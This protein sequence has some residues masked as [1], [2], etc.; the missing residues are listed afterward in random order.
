MQRPSTRKDTPRPW[1]SEC[2]KK[3]LFKKAKMPIQPD[4]STSI[5]LLQLNNQVTTILTRNLI[6]RSNSLISSNL[7]KTIT[8]MA[9]MRHITGMILPIIQMMGNHKTNTT[10]RSSSSHINNKTTATNF[11]KGI[12][13]TKRDRNGATSNRITITTSTETK[14]IFT[15]FLSRNKSKAALRSRSM[16]ILLSK[17]CHLQPSQQ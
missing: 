15:S 12:R 3:K 5:L 13:A 7:T 14:T 4:L 1:K 10:T 17:A 9:K 6:R 2:E 11:I 8:T 16:S